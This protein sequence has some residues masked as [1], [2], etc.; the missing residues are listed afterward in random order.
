MS[1]EAGPPRRAARKPP[2]V[3]LWGREYTVLLPSI[4]DPRLH[5]AAVL[6]TLQLLG[7]TVLDFRLSVAQILICLATGALF[8][9]VVGFFKDRVIMCPA[10]RPPTATPT[11]FLLPLPPTSPRPSS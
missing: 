7:Q 6:L 5:V 10:R 11:A 1:V 3:R 4:R 2:K 8:E 9:F